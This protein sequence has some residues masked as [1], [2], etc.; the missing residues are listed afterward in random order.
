MNDA[1]AVHVTQRLGEFGS[2]RGSL[3]SVEGTTTNP[4]C[5]RFAFDQLGDE[6]G[7]IVMHSRVEQTNEIWM[8][9]RFED[10]C[11]AGEPLGELWLSASA[12]A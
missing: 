10:G 1:S 3:C 9:E 2:E 6:E 12:R 5:Q 4:R 7:S 8:L 11:L